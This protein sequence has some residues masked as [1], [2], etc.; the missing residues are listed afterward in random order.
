M[1]HG[2][3]FEYNRLRIKLTYLLFVLVTVFAVAC[4]EVVEPE[5]NEA[6]DDSRL[7]SVNV[8]QVQTKVIDNEADIL[9]QKFI[10][11]IYVDGNEDPEF[12]N[13]YKLVYVSEQGRW[14]FQKGGNDVDLYWKETGEHQFYAYNDVEYAVSGS[15]SNSPSYEWNSGEPIINLGSI[16]FTYGENYQNF[17]LIY[18]K[19]SRDVKNDGYG[20]IEFPFKH[21]F[22]S[23]LVDIKNGYPGDVSV[24]AVSLHRLEFKPDPDILD[25]SS[26][27][28]AQ[29]SAD[30]TYDGDAVNLSAGE[31]E[32]AFGGSMLFFPQTFM[33]AGPYVDLTINNVSQ[34]RV[35]LNV[36]T[37][38]LGFETIK[39]GVKYHNTITLTPM[40]LTLG[41]T[42]LERYYDGSEIKSRFKLNLEADKVLSQIRDLKITINDGSDSYGPYTIGAV[43]SNDVTAVEGV[44]VE[45][46]VDMP[47]ERDY[48]ITYTFKD[49]I[50][51]E[52]TASIDFTSFA[53]KPQKIENNYIYS[54]GSQG[55]DATRNDIV[56]VII[57][58]GN[59]KTQFND[60]NLPN[61]CC[62][63]LAISVSSAKCA[64][65]SNQVTP[66]NDV[67]LNSTTLF[68]SYGTGGYTVRQMFGSDANSYTVFNT[69]GAAPAGTSGWYLP[70]PKEWG[71]I[72]DNKDSINNL[73]AG[74]GE[75]INPSNR[76]NAFWLPIFYSK[77]AGLV[78]FS[79]S[80]PQYSSEQYYY[81]PSLDS[82]CFYVRPVFAF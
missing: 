75:E 68:P 51:F 78:Y 64:W 14:R 77:N 4:S 19:T 61:T 11:Y 36:G 63:G 60:P 74:V 54:D 21:A 39:G 31:T 69:H 27:I 79:S 35:Y 5:N 32:A 42:D 18:C 53:D 67:K 65:H 25:F 15:G 23:L 55:N 66:P 3:N 72:F 29:Y 1:F 33:S 7:I 62:N 6:L 8:S 43:T 58:R 47:A 9:N 20:K 24:T 59:P 46:V 80:S 82:Y 44:E 73:M 71:Y 2:C 38:S 57:F 49:G 37:N 10:V 41:I 81:Y 45:G 40:N 12:Q 16:D 52:Y 13:P 48:T 76:S 28:A 70:T 26:G 17:D 30:G 50:N 34:K 22:A 56:G